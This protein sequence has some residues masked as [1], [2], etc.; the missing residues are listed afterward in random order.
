MQAIGFHF[1]LEPS[2]AGSP[3][4]LSCECRDPHY[5]LKQMYCDMKSHS[6]IPVVE[7]NQELAFNVL[8]LIAS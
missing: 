4:A 5:N 6:L 2:R 1:F 7:N 8:V 3:M